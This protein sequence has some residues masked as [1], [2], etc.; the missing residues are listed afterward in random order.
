MTDW[1]IL[2]TVTFL[3][4]VG[5]PLRTFLLWG[6]S[7]HIVKSLVG[8]LFGDM[9]DHLTPARV[10]GFAVYAIATT[11]GCAWAFRRLQARMKDQP[12]AGGDRKPRGSNR[13]AGLAPPAPRTAAK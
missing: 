13:R 1:P 11:V 2:S 6:G 12:P 8:V 4:L 3:P 5:V 7:I 9:S 10:T